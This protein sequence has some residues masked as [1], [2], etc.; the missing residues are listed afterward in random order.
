VSTTL[1]WQGQKG[2]R[3]VAWL[4]QIRLLA[5]PDVNPHL[6]GADASAARAEPPCR[7]VLDEDLAP[8]ATRRLCPFQAGAAGEVRLQSPAPPAGVL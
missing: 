3:S 4:R 7:T 6:H 5:T 2:R 8:P 1:G